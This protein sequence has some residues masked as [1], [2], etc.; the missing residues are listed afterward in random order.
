MTPIARWDYT[1]SVSP[2]RERCRELR[3]SLVE[4]S[5]WTRITRWVRRAFL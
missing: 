1:E 5:L 4:P 3:R 2:G